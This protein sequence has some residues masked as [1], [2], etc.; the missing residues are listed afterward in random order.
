MSNKTEK[1][2]FPFSTSIMRVNDTAVVSNVQSVSLQQGTPAE[3]IHF[4]VM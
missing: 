2:F 4:N 3:S 1:M